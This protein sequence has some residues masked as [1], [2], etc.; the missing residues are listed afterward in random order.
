V[1][2]LEKL[3]DL[4]LCARDLIPRKKT[5]M[6]EKMDS[7]LEEVAGMVAKR[8]NP[9]MLSDVREHWNVGNER[10]ARSLLFH[11][12]HKSPQVQKQKMLFWALLD[13]V[14]IDAAIAAPVLTPIE[15]GEWLLQQASPKWKRTPA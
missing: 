8:A 10:I 1:T 15:F 9:K 6:A 12:L 5:S 2:R 7:M 13:A 14:G 3:Y 4:L 11:F